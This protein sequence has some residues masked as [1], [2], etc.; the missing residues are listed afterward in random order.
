MMKDQEK[1]IG[2]KCIIY[3]NGVDNK[4]ENLSGY[5]Y[6]ILKNTKIKINNSVFI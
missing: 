1:D 6:T 4:K 2:P 3:V 5:A